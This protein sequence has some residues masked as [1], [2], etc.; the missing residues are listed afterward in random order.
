MSPEAAFF[1]GEPPVPVAAI[2]AGV[3][4]GVDESDVRGLDRLAGGEVGI[5]AFAAARARLA[6]VP[7]MRRDVDDEVAAGRGRR[8]GEEV[9]L[10]APVEER[11]DRFAVGETGGF[12]FANELA[13]GFDGDDA[14]E[15]WLVRLVRLARLA[16]VPWGRIGLV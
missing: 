4:F 10:F 15:V 2:F 8:G 3:R 1:D 14:V 12:A 6:A 9:L 11:G 7:C 5:A 16:P 13:V